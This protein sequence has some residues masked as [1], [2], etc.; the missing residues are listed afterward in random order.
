MFNKKI[1][2]IRYR[3][4]EGHDTASIFPEWDE[5]AAVARKLNATKIYGVRVIKPDRL[6]D[7]A[8][9]INNNVVDKVIIKVKPQK[10]G[11]MSGDTEED[12]GV[13][14]YSDKYGYTS[15]YRV[16][17]LRS[18]LTKAIDIFKESVL[19]EVKNENIN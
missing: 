2:Y 15:S 14:L 16:C 11:Y 10:E 5:H 18:G 6:M 3:N 7:L 13:V 12:V 8:R 17:I 19:V 4:D 1:K 9:S